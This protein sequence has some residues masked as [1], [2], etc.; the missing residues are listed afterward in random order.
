MP[1]LPEQKRL[2]LS[3]GSIAANWRCC[4]REAH[5]VQRPASPAGC[6]TQNGIEIINMSD[7]LTT[8]K[9]MKLSEFTNTQWQA[10]AGASGWD[11]GASPPTAKTGCLMDG[12]S[13]WCWTPRGG[14]ILVE[15]DNEVNDAG[16]RVLMRPFLRQQA[17]PRLRPGNPA[18]VYVGRF[19]GARFCRG[20]AGTCGR[21]RV[22]PS[23][24]ENFFTVAHHCRLPNLKHITDFCAWAKNAVKKALFRLAVSEKAWLIVTGGGQRACGKN[25]KKGSKMKSAAKTSEQE[26]Q[27]M[28]TDIA[29][30]TSHL[31][32]LMQANAGRTTGARRARL[33]MCGI[34]SNG[35]FP[36]TAGWKTARLRKRWRSFGTKPRSCTQE[37]TMK[38]RLSEN[39]L[40]QL[41]R[42]AV[43]GWKPCRREIQTG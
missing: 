39:E 26:C 37:K 1:L 35:R 13:F 14:C 17:A 34:C 31:Q 2:S 18:A 43:P 20:I 24:A 15:G 21:F 8:E 23:R 41:A 11:D 3:Q 38:N 28:R 27:T 5:P 33:S 10:F 19:S 30:L 4:A 36:S 6:L 40:L 29:Y 25:L 12:V 42:K 9:R 22:H 7:W 16:G 32:D